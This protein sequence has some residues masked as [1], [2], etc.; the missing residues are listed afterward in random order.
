[1]T[2]SPISKVV[3][4][5]KKSGIR[6]SFHVNGFRS[7]LCHLYCRK[8][9]RHRT[10]LVQG[11]SYNYFDSFGNGTWYNERSVEIPIVMKVVRRYQGRNIL[12]IGNVLSNYFRFDH[13]ILDKYENAKD[14]INA[15]VVD[16][17]PDKKYDLILSISTLEHV[18]WDEN[19]R[20]NTKI[21]QAIENLKTLIA[22]GGTIIV[23][24]PLG[25]N[26][27]LDILLENRLVGFTK[28]Y[29]LKRISKGNEWKEV[30]WK[31]VLDSEYNKP[32][33][34]A[35]GLFIGIIEV[36]TPVKISH[37]YHNVSNATIHV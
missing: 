1:L 19:P 26:P 13:D 30:S 23:T 24:L 3:N 17:K 34:G 35:N 4:I 33:A 28:Q 8:V 22:Q 18:G 37:H 36:D 27:H 7:L 11:D 12:E 20:D 2:F 5:S 29:Y 14:V 25:Y 32:F 10:F 6:Y 16:F 21:P 9:R 15:D 31:G